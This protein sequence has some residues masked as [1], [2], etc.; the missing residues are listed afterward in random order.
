M[1]QPPSVPSALPNTTIPQ[2]FKSFAYATATIPVTFSALVGI[3]SVTSINDAVIWMFSKGMC[4][5]ANFDACQ[6]DY[7]ASRN[8]TIARVPFAFGFVVGSI[9]LSFKVFQSTRE[10]ARYAFRA[11]NYSSNRA[12]AE[13]KS[14]AYFLKQEDER[15]KMLAALSN[16]KTV[17]ATSS[18]PQANGSSYLWA[19]TSFVVR[20]IFN[21]ACYLVTPKEKAP[22]APTTTPVVQIASSTSTIKATNTLASSL[23]P[24]T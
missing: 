16:P 24:N 1:A 15:Q 18:A 19:I 3:S 20:N 9:F 17:A 14:K 7:F 21:L 6:A 4:M 5:F 10:M 11:E 2:E 8:V 22:V 12:V 23:F 13:Q